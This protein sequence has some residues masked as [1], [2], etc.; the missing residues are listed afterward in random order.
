MCVC[1]CVC[2]YVCADVCVSV[3]GCV[4]MCVRVC[5]SFVHLHVCVCGGGERKSR[6]NRTFAFSAKNPSSI[7]VFL[8]NEGWPEPYMCVCV[9]LVCTIRVGQNHTCVY[10]HGVYSKGWPESYMCVC[11]WC[12]Q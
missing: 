8:H 9:Y 6:C 3:C 4:S 5:T 1:M 12:V 10:V 7:R 2:V 11:T